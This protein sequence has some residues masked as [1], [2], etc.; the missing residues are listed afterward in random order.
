M[1]IVID[2]NAVIVSVNEGTPRVLTLVR[3]PAGGA[4]PYGPFD[5]VADR[6]LEQALRRWVDEQTGLPLGYVEQLYTFGDA[7]RHGTGWTRPTTRAVSIGY[8]ALTRTGAAPPGTTWSPWYAFFPWEDWRAGE[9]GFIAARIR[10]ALENWAAGDGARRARAAQCFGWDGSEWDEERVLERFEL[11]YEANLVQER[12][13]DEPAE[14]NLMIEETSPPMLGRHIPFDHRRILATAI[15][16]LRGK[17]KYRPV[18]FELMPDTFT[19]LELQRCVE[20]VTGLSLHKQNFRRYVEKSGLT[21]PTGTQ[22]AKAGGRPAAEFRFR[23][24]ALSERPTMGMQ[25]ARGGM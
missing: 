2:L 12:W 8:L 22:S 25:V 18:V 21:E 11:L 10:L 1:T 7:G 23:R 19:L 17:L 16:R 20:A 13:R 4:L 6:T 3:A 5:P 9:P 15:S 24:E 14:E